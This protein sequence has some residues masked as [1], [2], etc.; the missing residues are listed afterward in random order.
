M[1]GSPTSQDMVADTNHPGPRIFDQATAG[2]SV[3]GGA[4]VDLSFSSDTPPPAPAAPTLEELEIQEVQH[5]TVRLHSG[6]PS[7]V[8]I[9]WN[10]ALSDIHNDI[11]QPD[12]YM[13]IQSPLVEAAAES[14]MHHLNHLVTGAP[15]PQGL[16][17]DTRVENVNEAAMSYSHFRV[18][19]Y[20]ISRFLDMYLTFSAAMVHLGR[21]RGAKFGPILYR[22][23][24]DTTNTL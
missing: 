19:M 7:D 16:C 23:S 1:P 14:L 20:I 5:G 6:M 18:V 8:A 13:V 4:S 24:S 3:V 17:P 11:E 21:V 9:L 22:D 12:A 2:E 10:I 15:I